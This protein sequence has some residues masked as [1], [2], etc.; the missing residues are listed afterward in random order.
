MNPELAAPKR[1]GRFIERNDDRD[2]PYYDGEPIMV[3][4]WKWLLIIVA[5]I[6]GFLAL[7]SI[8]R[9]DELTAL[10]PRIL[11]PAIPLTLFVVFTGKYWSAIFHRLSGRD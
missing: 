4:T 7:I 3:G 10:I 8:P 6:L 11:F 2:F 1:F 9:S 5:C